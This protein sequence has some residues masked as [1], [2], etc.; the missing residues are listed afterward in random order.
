MLA[1]VLGLSAAIFYGSADFLGG[2]GTKRSAMLTV[3]VIAQGVGFAVLLIAVP[4]FPAHASRGDFLYGAAGGICG[5]VGIALFYH[6]LSIGKMGVVSPIT[7]V[8]GSAFPVVVGIVRGD[9]LS[10]LQLVGIAIAL[11][12]VVLISLSTEASGEREI[13]T[14][15]VKEAIVAG[16]FIGAF[17]LLLA[18]ARS[19]AGLDALVAARVAS[20]LFLL[21]LAIVTRTNLRPP[22]NDLAIIVACGAMDMMANVFYVL[23]TYTGELAIAAVLTG[24]YPASTVFL[25]RFVLNERLQFQQKIGVGLALV[26]V[27]LIAV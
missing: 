2:I 3:T 7:A 15:G 19:S 5:G 1:I 25:A 8:I 27:S 18:Q 20:V 24:L 9:R 12:A 6:A 10:A 21:M 14:S 11:L 22:R 4:F 16:L 23:A 17:L 26:G 13:S